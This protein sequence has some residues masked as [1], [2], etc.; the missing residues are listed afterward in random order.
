MLNNLFRYVSGLPARHR[1]CE[2]NIAVYTLQ[3][4]LALSFH[5]LVVPRKSGG[6]QLSDHHADTEAL[7]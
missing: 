2:L 6:M 3:S 7:A 1:S 4:V 5:L